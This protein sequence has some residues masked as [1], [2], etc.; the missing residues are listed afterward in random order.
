MKFWLKVLGINL[1][2]L[3]LLMISLIILYSI[4]LMI[5]YNHPFKTE[6]IMVHE[7]TSNNNYI[8]YF[9]AIVTALMAFLYPISL[10]IVNDSVISSSFTSREVS[11]AVFSS[12]EYKSLRVNIFI[13]LF[14]CAQSYFNEFYWPFNVLNF[15]L[16]LLTIFIS[17]RY[18]KMLES[19]ISDFA[20]FVR[21]KEKSNVQ[22]LLGDEK[23]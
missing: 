10:T 2:I 12:I 3:F 13:L 19:I 18:I 20:Q 16:L 17:F 11:D 22:T 5:N 15:I 9:I 14:Y 23:N 4:L 7:W 1:A 8:G 6:L 21:D